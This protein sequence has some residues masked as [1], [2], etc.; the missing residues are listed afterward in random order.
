MQTE[1]ITLDITREPCLE[2]MVSLALYLENPL[3]VELVLNLQT[4]QHSLRLTPLGVVVGGSTAVPKPTFS[5]EQ[6]LEFVK[7]LREKGADL[8][9]TN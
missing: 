3:L 5:L 6:E 8:N 2:I 1:A 7:F 9:T 4:T